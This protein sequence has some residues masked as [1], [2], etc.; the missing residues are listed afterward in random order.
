MSFQPSGLLPGSA[1]PNAALHRGRGPQCHR[2]DGSQ[3][4]ALGS[5]AGFNSWAPPPTAPCPPRILPWQLLSTPASGQKAEGKD[6]LGAV[7]GSAE[8]EAGLEPS[9]RMTL[10]QG[11][12]TQDLA[13]EHGPWRRHRDRGAEPRRRSR[14]PPK[15]LGTKPAD[16]Q[17]RSRK[18]LPGCTEPMT[19]RH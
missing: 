15:E 7:H 6:H 2:R 9:G 14:Q 1:V 10:L 4:P 12:P 8:T 5:D 17:G 3:T 13:A 16:S 18:G 19:Q 11:P